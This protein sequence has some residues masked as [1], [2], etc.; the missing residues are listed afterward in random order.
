MPGPGSVEKKTRVAMGVFGLLLSLSVLL[1]P[2]YLPQELREGMENLYVL[3]SVSVLVLASYLLGEAL[4]LAPAVLEVLYGFLASL[5]GIEPVEI[6]ELLALIG[7]VTLMFSAGTEIELGLLLRHLHQSLAIGSLSFAA[8][9]AATAAALHVIGYGF[10]EAVAAS[11]GVSTTS[12]AVVYALVR[13][14]GRLDETMQ[15]ILASTMVVD[16]LSIVALVVVVAEANLEILGFYLAAMAVLPV[17]L[18]TILSRIPPSLYESEIRLIMAVLLAVALFSEI[19]GIHAVLFAFILGMAVS[20]AL[21][22]R[23]VVAG[24]VSG[25]VFGFLSPI[26]FINAGLEVKVGMVAA[27]PLLVPVMLLVPFASKTLAT[28]AGLRW[29]LGIR[30][31][32]WPVVFSAR[33]TVSILIAYTGYVK[34]ILSGGVAAA[35]ML[36]AL[37][38]TLIAGVAAGRHRQVEEALEEEEEALIPFNPS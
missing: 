12:V 4:L 37:M 35:I 27:N 31:W 17:A 25:I 10:R 13:S 7:S 29:L 18:A 38:A 34:G 23:P 6:V 26:F 16:L 8:P 14:A 11:V 9:F 19:A 36:T 24:K 2:L 3:A 32:K 28:Y 21:R 1:S 15:V 5:V 20:G 33:L 30:D 22:S